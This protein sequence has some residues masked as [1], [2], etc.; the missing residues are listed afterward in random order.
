M[1]GCVRSLPI[2]RFNQETTMSATSAKPLELNEEEQR[3]YERLSSCFD[4]ECRRVAKLLADTIAASA[5]AAS[6]PATSS[7]GWAFANKV[8]EPRAPR[9]GWPR[10][11]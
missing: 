4:E 7:W 3:I 6:F 11:G 1:R 10:W 8:L 9:V 5:A 2:F